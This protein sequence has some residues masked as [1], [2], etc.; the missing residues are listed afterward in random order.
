MQVLL[1]KANAKPLQRAL[2][3]KGFQVEVANDVA[4][5]DRR[6]I[7]ADYG[8]IV[9]DRDLLNGGGVELLKKWRSRGVKS[10]VVLLAVQGNLQ[11][12]LDLLSVG[13]DDFIVKP[14]EVED[15]TAR[16]GAVTRQNG[17]PE[18]EL[19]TVYDLQID[20]VARVVKRGGHSINLTPREFD[21]LLYLSSHRGKAVSRVMI[22]EHLYQDKAESRSNVV[23]VYIRYLRKKIDHGYEPALILTCWGKGY[24]LRGDAGPLHPE[25]P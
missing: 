4:D 18:H 15:L 10:H 13:A 21:L 20:P 1:F 8:V 6:A 5:A 24:M 12:K 23:D 19:V 2:E 16:L 17:R 14:I 3:R 7:A 22:W 9:L 11:D 25:A